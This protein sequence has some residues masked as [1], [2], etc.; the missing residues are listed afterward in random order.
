[1]DIVGEPINGS[2][3]WMCHSESPVVVKGKCMA[4]NAN[5][6]LGLSGKR[7]LSIDALRGFTMLWIVGGGAFIR[8]FE[9]VWKNPF[10]LTLHEQ[11]EHAGW[12]GFRFLDL[13]FPLFLFIVGVVL[14]FSVSRRLEKGEGLGN[15]YRHVLK[16]TIVLIILG[17]I[18]YGLLRFDWD[19]MR[20]SS[21]LG[22]IGI[23][24][25]FACILL[26]HTSW[27]MQA[28]VAAALMIFYWAA[29]MFIPVPGQGPGVLTPEGCLTT[30]L[31]QL[32]IL[33]FCTL[34]TKWL[35]LWF[36]YRNKIFFKA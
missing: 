2:V 1:M 17:L 10:T 7:L 14:P 23:C 36:L 27:R 4:Q 16:R 26:M 24:Y 12:Q 8:S 9:Q 6:G 25:F 13:I 28:L 18:N 29:V 32:I 20:W 21:V 3:H 11:M 33:S 22:R 5:T 19:Q 15:I 35:T 31:D 30:Y 34:M